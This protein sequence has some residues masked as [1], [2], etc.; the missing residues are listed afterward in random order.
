MAQPWPP[1]FETCLRPHCRLL[2]GDEPLDPDVPLAAL[3]VDSLE[4]VE[5]IVG[6]EAAFGVSFPDEALTP[7]VFAT[8]GA[9]WRALAGPVAATMPSRAV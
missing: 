4:V 7:E 1:E 9:V 3:G 2:D 6:L 5:L 8:A